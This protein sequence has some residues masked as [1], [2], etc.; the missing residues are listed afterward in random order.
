MAPLHSQQSSMNRYYGHQPNYQPK[1]LLTLIATPMNNLWNQVATMH[2]Q[3]GA[4]LH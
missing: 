1:E 2:Q 3:Q 4:M